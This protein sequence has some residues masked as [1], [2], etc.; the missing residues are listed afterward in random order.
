[1]VGVASLGWFLIA[2]HLQVL[3]PL[4]AF[5][6][7]A[8]RIALAAASSA[9]VVGIYRR[10]SWSRWAGLLVIFICAVWSVLRTDDPYPNQ[11]QEAGAWL[12]RVVVIPLLC[13]WWAY[14]FA[15][16]RKARAYFST[17]AANA[18]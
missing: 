18:V 7:F 8:W 4:G 1:L 3:D 2:E 10:A 5:F 12:G 6:A 11:A 15:F 16:S 9:T 17:V 14:A 13:V